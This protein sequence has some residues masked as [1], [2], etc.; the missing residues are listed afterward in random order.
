VNG[1][2]I[3][4]ALDDGEDVRV[5]ITGEHP[6]SGHSGIVQSRQPPFEG[7]FVV[8]LDNG[9][10]CGAPAAQLVSDRRIARE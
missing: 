10:E 4:R 7:W 1:Y 9:H 8:L 3:E 5:T 2:V 6:W